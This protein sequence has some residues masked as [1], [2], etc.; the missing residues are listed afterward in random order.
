MYFPGPALLS[1]S[2]TLS[3]EELMQSADI[4]GVAIRLGLA[5]AA[6]ALLILSLNAA[7]DNNEERPRT[8]ADEHARGEQPDWTY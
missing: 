3:E 1:R 6:F 7:Y 8:I 5:F 4:K 2:N